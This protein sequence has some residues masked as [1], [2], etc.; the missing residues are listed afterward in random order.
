[1][2]GA[3]RDAVRHHHEHWDGSG[4]PDGLAGGEIPLSARVVCVVDIYDALTSERAYRRR[5][6]RDE[7]LEVMN[8]EAGH[9]LDPDLFRVF[10]DEVLQS[11][12]G[13]QASAAPA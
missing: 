5:L 7:A 4:Y 1:M 13:R 6:S 10:R 3:V 2:S 9:T 8:E 11:P 12:I